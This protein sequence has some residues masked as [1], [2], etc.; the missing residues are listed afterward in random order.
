MGKKLSASEIA[1]SGRDGL[2]N[3]V[4]ALGAA[5]APAP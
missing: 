5:E 1:R 2:L 4:G 3:R